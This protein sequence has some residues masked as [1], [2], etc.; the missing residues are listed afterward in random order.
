MDHAVCHT[1]RPRA[2]SSA[3]LSPKARADH[4]HASTP[5]WLVLLRK[6]LPPALYLA[7]S[8]GSR[9]S[10]LRCACFW[11][12]KPAIN[13]SPEDWDGVSTIFIVQSEI[14]DRNQ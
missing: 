10:A 14:K 4:H 1:E 2:Q 7:A 6:I 12:W 9:L 11:I 13:V 3:P 5:P 8:L